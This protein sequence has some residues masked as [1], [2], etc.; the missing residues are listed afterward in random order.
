MYRFF[1][2]IVLGDDPLL[3][4]GKPFPDPYLLAAKKLQVNGIKKI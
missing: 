4:N 2:E 3:L 1:S